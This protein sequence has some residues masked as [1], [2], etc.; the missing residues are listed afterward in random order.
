MSNIGRN[1]PCPCGSG[2][3]YKKCCHMKKPRKTQLV[4]EL[5]KPMDLSKGTVKIEIDRKTGL[6]SF[7]LLKDGEET[8]VI[9]ENL[10]LAQYYEKGEESYAPFKM[11]DKKRKVTGFFKT[12]PEGLRSVQ[13]P[14]ENFDFVIAV[15]TSYQPNQNTQQCRTGIFLMIKKG[16]TFV[17]CDAFIVEFKSTLYP[18]ELTGWIIAI[19]ITKKIPPPDMSVGILVDYDLKRLEAI[20]SGAESIVEGFQLPPGFQFAYASSDKPNESLCNRV[21]WLADRLSKKKIPE[22]KSTVVIRDHFFESGKVWRLTQ[23]EFESTIR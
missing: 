3:K 9:A 23:H 1:D 7:T 16:E 13:D 12:T 5:P 8:K 2:L 10:A 19:A 4:F 20:N 21:I 6:P 22:E 11:G 17:P 18:Q 14:I 15:D